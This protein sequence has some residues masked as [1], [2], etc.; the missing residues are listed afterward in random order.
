MLEISTKTKFNT[1]EPPGV[2]FPSPL[3]VWENYIEGY[4]LDLKARGLSKRTV[5][6]SIYPLKGFKDF[7]FRQNTYELSF[8]KTKDIVDFALEELKRIKSSSLIPKLITLKGFFSYLTDRKIIAYDVALSVRLPKP[9]KSLPREIPTQDEFIRLIEVIDTTTIH[10]FIYRT[11]IELFYGTGMRI[12]E[13]INLKLGDIDLVK[14]E[15]HLYGSKSLKDRILPLTEMALNYLDAYLK[16]VR[17]KI[18]DFA[19]T[20]TETVFLNINGKN[21]DPR[22]INR[23]IKDYTKKAGIEKRLTSHSF[24]FAFATHLFENKADISYIST[25]LGHKSL[26]MTA[27]YILVSKKYLLETLKKHHPRERG[28]V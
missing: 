6:E 5:E 15:I 16:S 20:Q 18:L 22:T 3:D 9:P 8:V 23:K 7:C 21:F 12:N 14:G 25:L 28:R 17:E 19:E 26:S 11:V 2:Y 24:R 13:L 4:I 27:K 1:V 10:G